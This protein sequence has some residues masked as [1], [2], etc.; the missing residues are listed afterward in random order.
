MKVQ[1]NLDLTRENLDE[2]MAKGETEE[3][4]EM[5]QGLQKDDKRLGLD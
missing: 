1:E 3:D 5:I 4:I 2:W